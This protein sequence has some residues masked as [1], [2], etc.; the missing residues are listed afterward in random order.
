M[1]LCELT[2]RQ[3]SVVTD[4]YSSFISV[5]KLTTTSTQETNEQLLKLFSIHGLPQQIVSDNGPQ[6]R[7]EYK[8]FAE[9]L[10]IETI[11]SSPL[12]P[13][14]NGNVENAIKTVKRLFRKA[15]DSNRSEQLTLLEWNNTTT[16]NENYSPS[17]KLFG[18][19][20]RTLLL[21]LNKLLEPR[22][23]T[24]EEQRRMQI[25]KEKQ[26]HYFD[27][28]I[29]E[30]ETILTDDIIEIKTPGSKN[31]IQGTC[32]EEISPRKFKV[33]VDDK[34]YIRNRKI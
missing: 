14:S 34:T 7:T 31:W 2:N 11:Q 33:E 30:Y 26:K 23:E 22:H 28:N 18:R 16:E 21:I 29:R 4:Y 27:R 25:K 6:F 9:K 1:D 12:Y 10:D 20:S 24:E 5:A 8:K 13:K 32:I 19:K 17:D 3:L 15:I